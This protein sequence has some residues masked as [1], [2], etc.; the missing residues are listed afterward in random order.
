[1]ALDFS[2]IERVALK[3]LE[4]HPEVIERLVASLIDKLVTKLSNPNPNT[5]KA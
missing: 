2:L 5:P 4:D 3:Y 1:M